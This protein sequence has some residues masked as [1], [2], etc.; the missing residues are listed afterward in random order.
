ML[1]L[2]LSKFTESYFELV[3]WRIMYNLRR[4]YRSMCSRHLCTC[5]NIKHNCSEYSS[6]NRV[7]RHYEKKVNQ[8]N[9]IR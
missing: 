3:I 9:K 6:R 2:G 5:D 4:F 8:N 7:F 1:K